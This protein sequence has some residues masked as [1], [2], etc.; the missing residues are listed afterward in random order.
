MIERVKKMKSGVLKKLFPAWKSDPI[1]AGIA[2]LL[3]YDK[4]LEKARAEVEQARL[5]CKQ[6][7]KDQVSSTGEINDSQAAS[8]LA[9]KERHLALL[10]EAFSEK[11]QEVARLVATGARARKERQ[12]EIERA[13]EDL[14]REK[15]LNLMRDVLA[16]ARD[17]DIGLR[18]V[19]FPYH[20][21]HGIMP[22]P[23]YGPFEGITPEEQ[24]KLKMNAMETRNPFFPR[25]AELAAL[26]DES[27]RLT[28]ANII[29]SDQAVD[30]LL[31]W[32]R[33]R[34]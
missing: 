28:N 2:E 25:E 13:I 26:Q 34:Q 18:M 29:P 16:F 27:R 24:E 33:K 23:A 19:K 31:A 6:D 12:A 1:D 11:R 17:H 14:F 15:S 8:D 4:P 22:I 20:A 5:A 7:M 10:E 32:E 30:V 3:R 21:N 9:A